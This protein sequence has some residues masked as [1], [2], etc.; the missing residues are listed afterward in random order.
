MLD[1]G[2]WVGG[3]DVDGGW[4]MGRNVEEGESSLVY[5]FLLGNGG[6]QSLLGTI[7]T[8]AS[9]KAI[10]AAETFHIFCWMN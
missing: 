9:F 10:T 1:V 2:W 5:I 6:I 4:R 8:I 7:A 3:C